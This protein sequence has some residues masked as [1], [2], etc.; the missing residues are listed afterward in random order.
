MV[1]KRVSVRTLVETVM[2]SGSI[3]PGRSVQ[4]MLDGTRAHKELQAIEI[5]GAQNEV[6]V[7]TS[8]CSENIELTV[9]GR[10]DRLYGLDVV[11]EIKSTLVPVDPDSDA[12][13]QHWAQ[14]LCYAHMVC[15]A[16]KLDGIKVRITYFYMEDGEVVS[17]EKYHSV[18]S[19]KQSFD[20]LV[21]VY[22]LRLEIELKHTLSLKDEID[23][24]SFPF[25]Q[26]HDGQR[27]FA[28]RVYIALR[29]KLHMLAQAPTGTGKTMAVLFPAIKAIGEG[30]VERLFYLTARTTQQQAAIDAIRILNLSAL[31]TVVISA[32]DKVCM[33]ERPICASG[34][35]PL[36][37]GYYDR[38]DGALSE[39]SELSGVFDRRFLTD[40]ARRHMLCPF[41]LALDASLICDVIICDYNYAFDP[42]VRLQRYFTRGRQ[43]QALLVDE[44]HNLPDRAR[45]MYS[46]EITLAE[47]ADVKREI[48]KANRR[49][50]LYKSLLALE[51]GIKGRFEDNG[52]EHC[53]QELPLSLM[54]LMQRAAAE[55]ISTGMLDIS[56][57]ARQLSFDLASFMYFLSGSGKGYVTLYQG[58]KTTRR[59]TLFCADASDQLAAVYKKCRGI[60]LF[61][62]TLTPFDFFKNLCGLKPESPVFSLASPF[63]KE[64]LEVLHLAVNTRYKAREATMRRVAEAAASLVQSRSAGNYLIFLPSH[65]Y[66]RAFTTCFEECVQQVRM[67]VQASHMDDEA[68][69]T[70]LNSFEE[71]PSDVTVGIAV[72]GGVFA[73]G[74]DLPGSRLCGAVIVGVGLPQ[75]CLERDTLM[76]EF[77]ARYGD[78][79]GYAYT[80]PGIVKV[81]QAA[82]RVIRSQTDRGVVLLIDDRY[83]NDDYRPLLPPHWQIR[84]VFDGRDISRC[85]KEFWGE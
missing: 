73:E 14:A 22:L 19:L 77:D 66:L 1:E 54:P 45:G 25:A 30:H 61:S 15:Q 40:F 39:L 44:A 55:L 32:R 52:E 70:F 5:D 17:F 82:G 65:A 31:K 34:E 38:L 36:A 83:S 59:I 76:Q 9:Y 23:K 58:G 50:A 42:R 62:A 69:K 16:E 3:V 60:V 47:I 28:S 48:P 43:A 75:L 56:E 27:Q 37:D 11:E 33:Q 12:A 81:Q 13:E 74:I 46:T 2:L 80:Y 7:R 41:E 85:C 49:A 72:L 6:S 64:N 53:E 10:I 35:C 26:Y 78:G 29:D 67:I 8:V 84:R 57:Q 63:P 68:R 51:K 18:Q 79:Y 21:S 71:N 20:E 24:L 4:R